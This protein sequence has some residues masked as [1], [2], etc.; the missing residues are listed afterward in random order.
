MRRLVAFAVG[1]VVVVVVAVAATLWRDSSLQSTNEPQRMFPSLMDEI[2][3]VQGVRVESEHGTFRIVRGED[4]DWTLPELADYPVEADR[5]KKVLVS[6]SVLETLE[7][8]TSDPERHGALGPQRPH[9]DRG[10]RRR[11]VPR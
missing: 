2:N 3:S 1:T 11:G 7:P 6:L 8:R 10:R 9:R 5:V 4:G